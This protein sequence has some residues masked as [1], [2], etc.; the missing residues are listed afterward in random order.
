LPKDKWFCYSQFLLEQ[1][2]NQ[3]PRQ[4]YILLKVQK[5]WVYLVGDVLLSQLTCLCWHQVMRMAYDVWRMWFRLWEQLE[6]KL[7]STPLL[8][9]AGWRKDRGR[10]CGL[11]VE[12]F[13]VYGTLNFVVV[14]VLIHHRFLLQFFYGII[15]LLLQWC[16]YTHWYSCFFL[17]RNE[18]DILNS[19]FPS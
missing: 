16:C 17:L 15:G 4:N 7:L 12:I 9:T 11:L 14:I 10:N 8:G 2:S 3:L 6:D 18:L 13:G 19:Q 5:I 1:I